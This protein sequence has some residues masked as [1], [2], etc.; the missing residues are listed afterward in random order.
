MKKEE[1]EKIA[2]VLRNKKIPKSKRRIILQ[3]IKE[4]A[5]S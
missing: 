1:K 4:K 2:E 5:F 3:E